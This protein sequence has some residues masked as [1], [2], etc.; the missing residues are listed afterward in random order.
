MTLEELLASEEYAAFRRRMWLDRLPKAD[1][2]V[3]Q[4]L[5]NWQQQSNVDETAFVEWV[6]SRIRPL[7]C[8]CKF[9][10]VCKKS[11][12][13]EFVARLQL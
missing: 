3:K 6:R 10:C 4:M 2:E 7:D 12:Q 11:P 1:A 9:F 5:Q 8:N 13:P